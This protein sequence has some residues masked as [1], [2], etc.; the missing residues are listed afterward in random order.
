MLY[1]LIRELSLKRIYVLL[2]AVVVDVLRVYGRVFQRLGAVTQ[3]I[4]VDQRGVVEGGHE[5]RFLQF[6]LV[7]MG[8]GVA[9]V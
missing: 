7:R 3:R 5:K 1:Y 6:V 4:K 9:G 2:G 8:A